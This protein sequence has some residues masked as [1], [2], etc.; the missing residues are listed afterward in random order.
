MRV[1]KAR[2]PTKVNGAKKGILPAFV[3]P[4]LAKLV[5]SA[6]SGTNWLHEIKLDGYRM[7]ARIDGGEVQLLTRKGLD[8]T[9]KFKPVAKALKGLK[10]PSAL[11]DGEIVVEDRLGSQASRRCSRS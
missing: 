7:Q 8:W 11:L 2:R 4:A 3:E 10:L 5:E 9:A 6:P 1:G